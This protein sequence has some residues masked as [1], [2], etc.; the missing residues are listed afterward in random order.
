MTE[1][2]PAGQV[3]R[4]EALQV[5]TL[6]LRV[7]EV[8]LESSVATSDVE[9]AVRRLAESLGLGGCEVSVTLNLITLNYLHPSLDAPL[10]LMRVVRMG[11]PRLDRFLIDGHRIGGA[12]LHRLAQAAAG[13]DALPQ[14]CRTTSFGARITWREDRASPRRRWMSMSHTSLPIW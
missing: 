12:R 7:G 1:P 13:L 3:R 11:E 10:T 5:M 4:D 14:E 2:L 6:A 8:M 9:D